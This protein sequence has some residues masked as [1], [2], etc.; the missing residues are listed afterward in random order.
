MSQE[1]TFKRDMTLHV[2]RR[3]WGKK[4]LTTDIDFLEFDYD[5]DLEPIM[6]I[7]I[8]SLRSGWRNGKRTASMIAQ[9]KLAKK[10]DIPYTVVEH[11]DEW[12]EMIV[13]E[14]D[15][16]DLKSGIPSISK[17]QKMTLK[18]FVMWLY[19]IRGMK[20]TDWLDHHPLAG[21]WTDHVPDRLEPVTFRK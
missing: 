8:K 1:K 2:A 16:L 10:A 13:C 17:E 9:W 3:E 5:N 14:I 4:L 7:E 20:I 19:G 18:Q 21:H 6:L 11:N 15:S 12:S